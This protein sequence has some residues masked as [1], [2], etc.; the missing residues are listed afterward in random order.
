[1]RRTLNVTPG[2][3]PQFWRVRLDDPQAR[4]YTYQLTHH[5]KDGTV[6]QADPVTTRATALPVNDPFQRAIEIDFVPLLDATVTRQVF[7]DVQY[8]DDPNG[9]HR[10]ERLVLPGNANTVHLRIGLM[11]PAKTTYRYRL[12]F[13]GTINQM[14]QGKFIET[15]EALIAISDAP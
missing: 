15:K 8:D 13:V 14:K 2:S 12:T 6:K 11:D 4:T 7:I 10:Q 1:M 5:L 9:Y 3:Q